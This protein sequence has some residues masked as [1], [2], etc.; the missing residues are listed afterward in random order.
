MLLLVPESPHHLVSVGREEDAIKAL[1]WFRAHDDGGVH[2]EEV[3]EIR[4]AKEAEK[5]VEHVGMRQEKNK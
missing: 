2:A 3:E 5:R 4:A 1:Q